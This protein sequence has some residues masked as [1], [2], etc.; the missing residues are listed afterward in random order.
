MMKTSG[1]V[2]SLNS[3]NIATRLG[4]FGCDWFIVVTIQ[5]TIDAHDEPGRDDHKEPEV[6]SHE[7]LWP[8]RRLLGLKRGRPHF[9]RAS[10]RTIAMFCLERTFFPA[11]F[12]AWNS[13]LVCWRIQ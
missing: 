8:G 11:A 9:F 5:A 13:F 3:F 2:F 4:V 6:N 12:F 1:M 7:S 10:E